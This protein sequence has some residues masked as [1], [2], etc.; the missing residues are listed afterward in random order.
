MIEK[1][2]VMTNM[3]KS[4]HSTTIFIDTERSVFHFYSMVGNDRSTVV[5]QVKSY[6][7]GDF[8]EAFFRKFREAAED[9]VRNTP[10]R[11]VRKVTVVLPDRA[12][13][14]DTVKI[15]AMKGLGQTKKMLDVKLGGIYRN[16]GDLRVITHAMQQ[17]KQY[18][19]FAMAAVQKRIVSSVY[20]VCAEN[21]MLADTL[22]YASCAAVCGASLLDPRLKNESYLFLDIKDVCSR[23]VFV[24]NGNPVGYY[25]LPFGFEF[26][27]QP[28]VIPEQDL[29]DHSYASLVLQS[30]RKKARREAYAEALLE[31]D[32]ETKANVC[33]DASDSIGTVAQKNFRVFV[34]WALLLIRENKKLTE[35]GRPKFVCVNLP[36]DLGYLTDIANGE[37]KENGIVFVPL[38]GGDAAVRTELELYG[39]LFPKQIAPT[40]KF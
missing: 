20:A 39:G 13:L 2:G 11:F 28:Y 14:T 24:A 34:K 5:H 3:Q 8:D 12:V 38:A 7:A 23:F 37:E 1:K 9:F 36:E 21:K 30:A 33:P 16:Y 35:L 27:R 17:N 29:F 18:S 10:S 22:T 19:S 26:L 31:C 6:T 32:S 15:P 40:G 25:T 4:N